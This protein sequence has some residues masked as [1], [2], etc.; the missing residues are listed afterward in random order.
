MAEGKTAMSPSKKKI[1]KRLQ[2]KNSNVKPKNQE[3]PKSPPLELP[4]PF[5]YNI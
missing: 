3:K 2:R 1:S 4:L 5:T